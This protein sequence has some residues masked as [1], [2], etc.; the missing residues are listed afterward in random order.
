[1]SD[2]RLTVHIPNSASVTGYAEKRER[3]VDFSQTILTTNHVPG[4]IS[5]FLFTRNHSQPLVP[6][7]TFE[8]AGF[9]SGD[10]L[11]ITRG[12]GGSGGGGS[13]G[14]SGSMGGGGNAAYEDI[15]DVNTSKVFNQLGILV[16][17]GSGS[18]DAEG[19]G[20][21]KLAEHVNR[22]VREFLGEFKNISSIRP[23]VSIAVITFDEEAIVHTKPVE[24]ADINDF[25]DYNPIHNH[26]RGTNIGV[27]LEVA[28]KLANEHLNSP[29]ARDLPTMATIIVL[30]DG[31]CLYPDYT[32]QVV[33][34]LKQSAW[35][36]QGKLIICASYFKNGSVE[37]EYEEKAKALLQEMVSMP[38]LYITSYDY[39]YLRQ[40]F[41]GSMSA[42]KKYGK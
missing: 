20:G 34:R 32:R 17:D 9:V 42:R 33:G 24:L 37:K 39:K 19:A 35:H 2:I 14:S 36:Q 22:A 6:S 31:V 23:N 13:M 26:G 18:M 15:S 30:S 29:E 25:A 5:E 11:Y 3:I 8:D 38:N 4:N 16:L 21:I 10:E 12:S 1:M 7:S 40:F 27:A 41:I 28:E